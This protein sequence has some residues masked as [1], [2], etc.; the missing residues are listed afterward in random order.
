MTAMNAIIAS[1]IIATGFDY[2]LRV[3]VP[4]DEVQEASEE[5]PISHVRV[6]NRVPEDWYAGTLEGAKENDFQKA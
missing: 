2:V 3:L 5:F 4:N 1:I 6:L